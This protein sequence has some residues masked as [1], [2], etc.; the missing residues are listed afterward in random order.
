MEEEE[1]KLLYVELP[2]LI[3]KILRYSLLPFPKSSR[4][5]ELVINE[6]QKITNAECKSA[7]ENFKN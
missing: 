2:N 3:H 6:I 5:T 1:R 4:R 7:L